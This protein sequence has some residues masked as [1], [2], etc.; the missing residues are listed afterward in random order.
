MNI[1]IG[2]LNYHT[3]EEQLRQLFGQCGQVES[4]SII[5]DRATG[6]PRGF[7]FIGMSDD[8]EA[9][10][11]IEQFNGQEFD[12]RTLTVNQAKARSERPQNN[13]LRERSGGGG[14]NS[15]DSRGYRR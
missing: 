7:G 2:N 8:S 12:G 4:A 10:K 9:E 1:Y 13:R 15:S 5:T 3:T 14:W 11:A 6:R